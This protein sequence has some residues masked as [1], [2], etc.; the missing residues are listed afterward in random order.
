[1]IK[2]MYASKI[3]QNIMI[4]HAFYVGLSGNFKAITDWN[5]KIIKCTHNK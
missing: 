1:M 4:L 2:K 3:T 5:L